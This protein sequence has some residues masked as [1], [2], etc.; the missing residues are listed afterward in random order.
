MRK[1]KKADK[2]PEI[3][4]YA[5]IEVKRTG[6]KGW[7]IGSRIPY[8]GTRAE[9]LINFSK[10][11]DAWVM[12]DSVRVLPDTPSVKLAR[13]VFRTKRWLRAYMGK[14]FT[15]GNIFTVLALVAFALSILASIKILFTL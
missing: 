8:N 13:A 14:I 2:Q 7:L 3:R 4:R 5:R 12:A 15:F 11:D 9:L 10:V 6:E 1:K